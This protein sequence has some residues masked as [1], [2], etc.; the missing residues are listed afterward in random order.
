MGFYINPPTVSKEQW[1]EDNGRPISEGQLPNPDEHIVCLVGNGAFT[2][3]GIAY[4]TDE[5]TAFSFPDRRPK[6]W[7]AVKDDLIKEV[8]PNAPLRQ[9]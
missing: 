2:A 9:Y 3:A 4:D 6:K 5:L 8:A 7:F 1:L